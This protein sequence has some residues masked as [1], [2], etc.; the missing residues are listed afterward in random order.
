MGWRI[1]IINKRASTP[2]GMSLYIKPE[3][4]TTNTTLP[5]LMEGSIDPAWGTRED[6]SMNLIAKTDEIYPVSDGINLY[7]RSVGET[8][9]EI[10]NQ[11]S[12]Y[13]MSSGIDG[14]ANF[15][16]YMNLFLKPQTKVDVTTNMNLSLMTPAYPTGDITLYLHNTQTNKEAIIF[17]PAT[18]GMNLFLGTTSGVPFG[19][20]PSSAMNL[21]MPMEGLFGGE[22]FASRSFDGTFPDVGLDLY[23]GNTEAT[24]SM[25]LFTR[26]AYSAT[27]V[28]SLSMASVDAVHSGVSTFMIRGYNDSASG[29]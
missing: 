11:T 9:I 5:M 14:G 22:Q 24:G 27:G 29:I 10:S 26:A 15:A 7:T 3:A 8:A 23:I 18:G 16:D 12:L 21:V 25:P 20:L 13:M 6:A 1:Q 4:L 17:T 28:M 2:D 19:V